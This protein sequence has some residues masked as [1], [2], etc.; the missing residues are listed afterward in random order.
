MTR[1][2]HTTRC[3][4]NSIVPGVALQSTHPFA[5]T[6]V[7]HVDIDLERGGELE[8]VVILKLVHVCERSLEDRGKLVFGAV[9]GGCLLS[10]ASLWYAR[11]AGHPSCLR[12]ALILGRLPVH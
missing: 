4:H 7:P 5:S 1:Y 8:V 11:H 12:V 6:F 2:V 9:L 10:I 3:I